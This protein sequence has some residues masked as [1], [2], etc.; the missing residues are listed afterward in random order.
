MGCDFYFG[1][2]YDRCD[3]LI[4]E[5]QDLLEMEENIKLSGKNKEKHNEKIEN[6]KKRI[7]EMLERINEKA[8]GIAQID[9]LQRL[10]EKYQSLLTEES[11]INNNY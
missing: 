8:V 5:Y 10:N 3:I 1:D 2:E 11:K 7:K 4:D 9:K 6:I